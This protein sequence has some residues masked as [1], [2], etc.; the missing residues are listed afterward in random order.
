V[1]DD[2][3]AAGLSAAAQSVWAK[4]RRDPDTHEVDDWMP[5]WQHLDDTAAVAHRLWDAWLPLSVRRQIAGF[6]GGDEERA[7]RLVGW[8]AGVHDVGKASP[9][10]AVQF[11][12]GAHRMASAGLAAAQSAWGPERRELR[13]EL[14][15]HICLVRWLTSR[16][17]WRRPDADRLAVVVGGHHGV[18]PT[19][20]QLTVGA[21][22]PELLGSGRWTEVQDEYLDRQAARLLND[23][24]L[25][26]IVSPSRPVQALLTALVIVADW[27]A[28]NEAYF[29]Y[30]RHES[31]A[32]RVDRAWGRI[33]L[34]A[35]WAADVPTADAADL[36]VQRFGRHGVRPVQ[37]VAVELA[38]ATAEPGLLVIEAPMGEGKTEAALLAAEILAARTGAG[39]CFIALPTQAT[40]DAMFTRVRKWLDALPPDGVRS[41]FLAHGRAS[42]NEDYRELLPRGRHISVAID[43]DD[44][45]PGHRSE[46]TGWAPGQAVSA[47]VHQWLSGRKKG[48]LASFVV[49]TVDQTLFLALKSRH[50][51]LRHLALAGKVVVIDEVHAYDV[52]MG[53]YL[54]KALHWLGAYGAPVVLLSATLPPAR[55]EELIAAYRSGR[56]AGEVAVEAGGADYPVLTATDGQ[57]VVRRPTTS[58]GRRTE[59]TL[60]FVA[61]ADE[62]LASLA[63][64]LHTELRDGGCALVVRST[65]GRAQQAG[66]YL[67][68]CFGAD[69][70]TVTHARFL[71]V[72]RAANDR[73]LLHRFGPPGPDV[74]RPTW[75]VVVGTQVVEQSLDVDFDLLVTDLAPVDLVLQRMG[76]LHRHARGDNQADRPAPLRTARCL[77]TG[78][79]RAS[80]PPQAER[81]TA[82]VY[83]QD[84]L[85]RSM[86]VLS[87][88]LD[89]GPPVVLPDHIAPLVHRAYGDDEI[90]PAE[91]REAMADA[92][93]KAQA[94]AARRRQTAKTFQLGEASGSRAI[95]GWVDAGVGTAD[96]GPQGEAQVRDGEMTLEVLVV[97]RTADGLV[98]PPWV[99]PHGGEPIA[100]TLAIEPRQSR[101][102]ASCAL[103]LPG[104]LTRDP[105]RL[106]AVIAELEQDY[107][108]AWQTSPLLAGQ[109]VMVLD[110]LGRR[111]LVGEQLQYT[112]ALGLE[113]VRP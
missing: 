79:D 53:S 30:R 106:D 101:T 42:L 52:Y 14:A 99:T 22:R 26:G 84:A 64:R 74:E 91:W 19:A 35:P 47:V 38:A 50:L 29:G 8:L 95:L 94:G 111:E 71:A 56:Q 17:G 37:V 113:V 25:A 34:P 4:T 5:L 77:L 86:A 11:P 66:R 20:T 40:T 32:T 62:E 48:V 63:E 43:A 46:A 49:G 39:G 51:V 65:V 103:R 104:S 23:G 88:H 55:R 78:V 108:S 80:T 59:V 110:E 73:G 41:V 102:V 89:G 76:R 112:R 69:R 92:R 54:D 6:L 75:H 15:G 18:A 98:V 61:A 57:V 82:A 1:V 100:T 70:V 93:R 58:A 36:L 31:A 90:G 60:E 9:A 85:L 83:E 67:T 105:R 13:H 45:R 7:R 68:E 109:L 44:D 96:E 16:H 12:D 21:K 2:D 107:I 97:V 24:D 33:D 72:D 87:P 3:G 81:G 27:I 10:F 28:S